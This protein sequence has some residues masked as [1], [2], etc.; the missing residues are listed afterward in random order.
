MRIID[1]KFGGRTLKAPNGLPT[2]PTTDYARSGL[3][4][5]LHHKID[6]E[7][8]EVLDLFCGTG[9]ISIEMA[10]RG[11]GLVTAVD[12]HAA[13]LKFINE[14]AVQWGVE[15]IQTIKSDALKFLEKTDKKFDLIFADPPFELEETDRIPALVF[16]R[17]LLHPGG[18]LIVEH[19][20]KRILPEIAL[21]ADRRTYGNCT[22]SIY[23]NDKTDL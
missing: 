22:F 15:G 23:R 5:I 21:P 19:Q 10:S 9:S 18:W 13:C 4:N 16:E 8:L 14:T 3:F 20:A 2:R 6:F 7:E 17:N 12:R 1:G 11:A